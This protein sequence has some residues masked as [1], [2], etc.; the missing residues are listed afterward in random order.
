MILLLDNFDSFTFNLVDY[1]GRLGRECTVIRNDVALEDIPLDDFSALV[2]SPGPEI[3]QSSGNLMD[4]LEAAIDRYPVLGICLGHQ[5]IGELYGGEVVKAVHPMHGK[6]SE[7][8]VIGSDVLFRGL[9]ERFSVVRYNSLLVSH[10]GNEVQI[11]AR[12]ATGEIMALSHTSKPIH[13]V[14][15]HPEAILTEYGIDILG[16]WLDYY[17]IDL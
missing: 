10:P 17:A 13:G 8:E 4:V 12:T 5:A 1:L 3:P 2:I 14:Q 16:N 6:I 9:P 7:I 11:T 15:F